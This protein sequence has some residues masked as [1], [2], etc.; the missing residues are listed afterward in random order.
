MALPIIATPQYTLEQP[1]TGKQIKF[2][3]FL[4]KEEK[5]LLMALES[6]DS[7]EA[8]KATKQV[9]TNCCEGLGDIDTLPMFDIEFILLQLRSKSVGEVAE[10]VIK[11]P[12]CEGDIKLK[13]DLSKV[14]VVKDKNHTT[15]IPITDTIG[16]IMKYPTYSLLQLTKGKEKLTATETMDLML[17]C[18]DFIYDG[19]Q[20]YKAS[21]QTAEELNEF[22][23]QMTQ[24]HFAK[25]QDFFSTMPRLEHTITYT[26]TNKV[27]TGDIT[28]KKCGF[29]G[30]LVLENLQD[31]FV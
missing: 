23:E 3:P 29:K 30:K 21:E 15:K 31:F 16:L 19:D 10:P 28:S 9:I 11:C 7:M 24:A 22:V 25:I 17:T 4:V 27:R 5:I 14:S 18:I 13:V 6:D 1:S 2:R 20:N 26:C 12:E 8:V